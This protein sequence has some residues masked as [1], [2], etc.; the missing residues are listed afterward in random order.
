MDGQ[1]EILRYTFE[2]D[3]NRY[4]ANKYEE[5]KNKCI[6]TRFEE[7]YKKLVNGRPSH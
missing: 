5:C 3:Q 1:K 6:D 7:F 2:H 4:F